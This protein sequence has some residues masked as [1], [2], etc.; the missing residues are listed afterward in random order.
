MNESEIVKNVARYYSEKIKKFGPVPQGVDW[1]GDASQVLRFDQL[2]K[3]LTDINPKT[4]LLDYGC[5]YGA[6]L[7]YLKNQN[8]DVKYTGFDI[9]IEMI[10]SAKQISPDELWASSTQELSQ[11]DYVVASGV[12]NVKGETADSDWEDYIF[13]TLSHID[14]LSTKGFAFNLLTSYSDKEKMKE[15]LFYAEPHK[16]FQY[17]KTHFSKSVALLHDYPLYEFT[18]LVRKNL[19]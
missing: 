6:L 16:L 8:I 7:T 5:G 12:F 9:S 17:C 1:N 18:I 13:K 19:L 2:V 4:S 14:K 11:H 10:N 15:N 3:L